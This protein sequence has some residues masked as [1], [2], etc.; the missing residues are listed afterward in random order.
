MATQTKKG[1]TLRPSLVKVRARNKREEMSKRGGEI[2]RTFH[3]QEKVESE[4][5]VEKELVK[6]GNRLIP[7][8]LEQISGKKNRTESQLLSKRLG[9]RI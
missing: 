3:T 5:Q 2:M 6:R 1:A 8:E 4:G 9:N 7:L